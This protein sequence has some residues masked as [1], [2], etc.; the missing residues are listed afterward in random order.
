MTGVDPRA[1]VEWLS[2]GLLLVALVLA[3]VAF[4]A[5]VPWAWCAALVAVLLA[6]ALLVG[7]EWGAG[8]VTVPWAPAVTWGLVALIAV[9]L[10]L[11]PLPSALLGLVSPGARAL[12]EGAGGWQAAS[13]DR[14]STL[15]ALLLGVLYLGAG[16]G[17]ARVAREPGRARAVLLVLLGLCAFQAFY[18]L[19]EQVAGEGRILFWSKPVDVVKSRASGTYVNPNHFAGFLAM[20]VPVALALAA[21]APGGRDVL[22]RERGQALLLMLTDPDFPKRVLLAFAGVITAAGL[23]GS[24]SR[25]GLLAAV[26]GCVGVVV[27]VART[28]PGRLRRAIGLAALAGVGVV[29]GSI[30]LE[31]FVD[32]FRSLAETTEPGIP[33]RLQYNLDTLRMIGAYPVLGVGA[34][35]FEVAFPRFDS[36]PARSFVNHAHDDYVQLLV[37][38]GVVPALALLYGLFATARGAWRAARTAGGERQALALTALVALVP[39][40]VHALVDF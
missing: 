38:L 19:V 18:G 21:T 26:A 12:T 11:V 25:G 27:V 7:V 15:E 32:R 24:F 6:L 2:A 39:G 14:S 33:G 34:G 17:A 10:Q 3:P 22:P 30:A 4:G 28:S 35:A 37:E 5:V 13:L 40:A 36:A 16:L 31:A 9:T 1:G 29:I 20:G 8:V 23:A